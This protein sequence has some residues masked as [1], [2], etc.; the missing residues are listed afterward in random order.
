MWQR[1][2]GSRKNEAREWQVEDTSPSQTEE[3][4][5]FFWVALVCG[6]SNVHV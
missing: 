4:M 3:T 2:S 5:L 6:A 1:E